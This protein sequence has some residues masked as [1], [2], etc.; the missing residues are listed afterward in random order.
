M[1]EEQVEGIEKV[2]QSPILC[3]VTKCA[4]ALSTYPAEL[5]PTN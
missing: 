2:F 1:R 5:P 4:G 3:Y